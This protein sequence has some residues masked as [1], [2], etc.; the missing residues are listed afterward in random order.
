M[1]LGQYGTT[2]F[3][4][5][6]RNDTFSNI[7]LLPVHFI[8]GVKVSNAGKDCIRRLLDKN[9]KS[10]LGSKTGASEVKQH[11]WFSKIHWG[12][13]RNSRP[14]IIPNRVEV[15]ETRMDDLESSVPGTERDIGGDLFS[16][17]SSVTLEYPN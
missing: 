5:A 8:E 3:K 17:F 16:S 2:P 15:G 7:R 13:L 14:P 12:L 11:K 4:G 1:I 6:E 10:R 9:E